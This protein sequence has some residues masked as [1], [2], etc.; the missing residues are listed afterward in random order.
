MNAKLDTTSSGSWHERSRSLRLR[1][2]A[3]ID[4]R[5]V[6]AASGQT[7]DCI[8]PANGAVLARV[9]ACDVEDVNRAVASARAVFR[10][11]SWSNLAPAK[12]KRLLFR[13]AELINKH[14]D[15]LALL[16]TLDMGKPISDSLKV[17][18]PG[19]AR[20]INWYAEAVDKIYD[21]VAP[22]GPAAL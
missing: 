12:R 13:F 7:F 10:K 9:A 21:E 16:E 22:T 19:A 15:E 1:T 8:N 5:Y 14:T 6:D 20:C 17:D 3:F 18:I 11:G 4:G 2:Q